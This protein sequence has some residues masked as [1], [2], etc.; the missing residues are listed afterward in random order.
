MV[1]VVVILIAGAV[2][3]LAV[4]AWWWSGRSLSAD[5]S[6]LAAAERGEAESTRTKEY[7]ALRRLGPSTAVA[8]DTKVHGFP[9]PGPG[10]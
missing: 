8:R 6:P 10:R 7:L 1:A 9:T 3:A 5:N 4:L 2:V